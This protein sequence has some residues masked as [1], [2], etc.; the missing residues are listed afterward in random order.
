MNEQYLK[1]LYE[2]Y[3]TMRVKNAQLQFT[4]FEYM[5]KKNEIKH[6]IVKIRKEIKKIEKNYPEFSKY[7]YKNQRKW[8][9]Q[10]YRLYRKL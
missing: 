7:Y 3:I 2:Y 9:R 6:I 4:Y 5:R 8:F 10:T 1:S